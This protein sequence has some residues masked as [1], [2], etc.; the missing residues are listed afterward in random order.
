MTLKEIDVKTFE[1]YAKKSTYRTFMQTEEIGKLRELNGWTSYYLG[2][3]DN[4]KLVGATLLVGKKRHFN[5]YEF[6][7]PRGPLV[8]YSHE[9][10]TPS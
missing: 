9:K 4:D 6:Y 5:K 1:N 7:S 2:L 10:T 3:Y 8:D